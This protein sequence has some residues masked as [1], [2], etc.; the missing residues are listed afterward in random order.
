MGTAAMFSP[1]FIDAGV[2]TSFLKKAKK[3]H[4]VH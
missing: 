1:S 4:F 3:N 2:F